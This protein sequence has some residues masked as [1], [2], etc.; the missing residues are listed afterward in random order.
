MRIALERVNTT[1]ATEEAFRRLKLPVSESSIAGKDPEGSQ[2]F[3]DLEDFKIF[4]RP[5]PWKKDKPTDR[6]P[7]W[8]QVEE[9]AWTILAESH[10]L[11]ALASLA[12]AVIRTNGWNSFLMVFDVARYDCAVP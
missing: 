8:K 12:A 4:G 3:R 6:E 2:Q 7:D 1:M 10:D 9:K 5:G 11:R